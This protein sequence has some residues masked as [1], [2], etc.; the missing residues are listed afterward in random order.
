MSAVDTTREPVGYL[1][2]ALKLEFGTTPGQQQFD[3]GV[4][5]QRL[6]LRTAQS[7][8]HYGI[9]LRAAD[10][11]APLSPLGLA[12]LGLHLITHTMNTRGR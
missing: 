10:R 11:C 4:V 12:L 6:L 1:R 9:G 3:D 5:L 2:P 8:P 7:Q